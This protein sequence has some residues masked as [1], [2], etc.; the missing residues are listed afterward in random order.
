MSSSKWLDFIA[1]NLSI[2]RTS[3]RA[4][5]SHLATSQTLANRVFPRVSTPSIFFLQGMT[6]KKS[7]KRE[8]KRVR[9]DALELNTKYQSALRMREFWVVG[10][11]WKILGNYDT[12]VENFGTNIH[13]RTTHHRPI[14]ASLPVS[15]LHFFPL[16]FS[17]CIRFSIKAPRVHGDGG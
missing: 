8:R 15:P 12:L 16:V 3:Y 5:F 7:A 6:R 13:T 11:T 9:S 1:K 2:C 4:S 10:E 14:G 17:L